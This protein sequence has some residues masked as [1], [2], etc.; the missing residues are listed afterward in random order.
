MNLPNPLSRRYCTTRSESYS[1]SPVVRNLKQVPNMVSS[2]SGSTQHSKQT[3]HICCKRQN[4]PITGSRKLSYHL[5][6]KPITKPNHLSQLPHTRLT[7]SRTK[8]H[9]PD[10]CRTA[11]RQKTVPRAP[12][13]RTRKKGALTVQVPDYLILNLKP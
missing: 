2:T 3:T 6:P 9:S 8:L 5:I 1:N 4:S 7:F 10:K 11:I 13:I 12:H